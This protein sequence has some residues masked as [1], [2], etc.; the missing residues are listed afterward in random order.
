MNR[1]KGLIFFET[2]I[3]TQKLGKIEV[4]FAPRKNR[5]PPEILSRDD[6]NKT[7]EKYVLLTTSLTKLELTY[8]KIRV[9][10]VVKLRK[11]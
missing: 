11:S 3:Y 9:G 4:E 8:F 10:T 7:L 6:Q 1:D 5:M 2:T